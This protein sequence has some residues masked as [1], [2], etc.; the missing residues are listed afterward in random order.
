MTHRMR[1]YNQ[2]A[3]SPRRHQSYCVALRTCRRP[4][5]PGC[6]IWI[7]IL[8]VDV[9][10]VAPVW[11]QSER[12]TCSGWHSVMHVTYVVQPPPAWGRIGQALDS[13]NLNT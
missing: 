10:R 3:S 12:R 9:D 1:L 6:G 2:P 11:L 13:Q 8:H 4:D 7:E 5:R